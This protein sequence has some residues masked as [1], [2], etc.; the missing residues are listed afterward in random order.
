MK[1]LGITAGTH[2]SGLAYL[3]DGINLFLLLK[4]KDLIELKVIKILLKVFGDPHL[5]VDKIH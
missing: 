2:S 1:I 5:K 3:E 4:K